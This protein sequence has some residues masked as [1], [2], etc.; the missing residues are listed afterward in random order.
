MI[1]LHSRLSADIVQP[2]LPEHRLR[3]SRNSQ[4]P[5]SQG[6]YV[7]KD[8][9]GSYTFTIDGSDEVP[10]G[11]SGF[12][13]FPENKS[14]SVKFKLFSNNSPRFVDPFRQIG[15]HDKYV[16]RGWLNSCRPVTLLEP[17]Y[18]YSGVGEIARGFRR[19]S[20][21]SGFVDDLVEGAHLDS[22]NASAISEIGFWSEALVS[23]AKMQACRKKAIVCEDG[24][25]ETKRFSSETDVAELGKLEFTITYR[26]DEYSREQVARAYT[27]LKT[28]N[29]VDIWTAQR[30]AR[31]HLSF[32]DFLVGASA[33]NF[34]TSVLIN[35]A[36]I[37]GDIFDNHLRLGVYPRAKADHPGKISL[38][39]VNPI[40]VIPRALVNAWADDQ[41]KER[42]LAATTLR[43]AKLGVFER[44]IRT[45]AFLEKWLHVRYPDCSERQDRFKASVVEY[46][47]H[48]NAASIKVRDFAQEFARPRYPQT[49]NLRGLLVRA[50]DECRP[51]GLACDEQQ[52][53]ILADRRH[54][55][56]HG[57][58]PSERD[59]IHDLLLGSDIGLAVIELLTL[60]DIGFDP[61][62]QFNPR[63]DRYGS[64]NGIY[65]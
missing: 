38:R 54:E 25:R 34:H 15:D 36:E 50:F 11:R 48:L 59:Q 63:H 39:L 7:I 49:N 30:W 65:E 42:I 2:N 17:F 47:N 29:G 53:K 62:N 20:Q 5:I 12:L 27:R 23:M 51:L 1:V 57:N 35:E 45:I 26:E 37:D 58:E 43:S 55:I 28:D 40:D 10:F 4:P 8:C 22:G 56:A 6:L 24:S 60:K 16:V 41:I 46:N 61:A 44:F 52:A 33:G 3:A 21:L 13:A 31:F 9:S 64:Q 14:E 32:I 18:N 19:S